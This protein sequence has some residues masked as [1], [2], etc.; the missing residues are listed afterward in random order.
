[1]EVIEELKAWIHW[2][3]LESLSVDDQAFVSDVEALL[4]KNARMREALEKIANSHTRFCDSWNHPPIDKNKTCDC[5]LNRMARA[6][7][8]AK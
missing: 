4:N 3:K 6:A 2:K 5:I 7:L 1:V 8:E